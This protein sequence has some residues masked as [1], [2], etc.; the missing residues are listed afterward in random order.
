MNI[1]NHGAPIIRVVVGSP[2]LYLRDPQVNGCANTAGALEGPAA[3]V[4]GAV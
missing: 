3:A 1:N 2:L 4:G